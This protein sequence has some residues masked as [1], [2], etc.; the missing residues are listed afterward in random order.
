MILKSQ[1]MKEYFKSH[2]NERK[3]IVRKI[4][5]LSIALNKSKSEL[6][7]VIPDYLQPSFV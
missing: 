6:A 5:D 3:L 7:D 2:E 4:N 1:Q